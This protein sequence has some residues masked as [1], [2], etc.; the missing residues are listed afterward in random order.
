MADFTINS[1]QKDTIE[2]PFVWSKN[3]SAIDVTTYVLKV[4]IGSNEYTCTQDET[5]PSTKWL[6]ITSSQ[7][8][9]AVGTHT[10]Y[11]VLTKAEDDFRITLVGDLVITTGVT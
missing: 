10:M 3:G 1:K 4:Y 8:T 7:N 9:F 11:F 2:I 6:R 5:L